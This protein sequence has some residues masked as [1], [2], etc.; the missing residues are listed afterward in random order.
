MFCRNTLQGNGTPLE[1]APTFE[2]ALALVPQFGQTAWPS[3]G[4]PDSG[5]TMAP[6]KRVHLKFRPPSIRIGAVSD[7][8]VAAHGAIKVTLLKNSSPVRM[9]SWSGVVTNWSGENI[10]VKFKE[11]LRKKHLADAKG[12]AADPV[13][14]F[15]WLV[16][17]NSPARKRH[18]GGDRW[19]G[20]PPAPRSHRRHF[21]HHR[22]RR[23][24]LRFRLRPG[25]GHQA[26]SARLRQN[27]GKAQK[28]VTT[29]CPLASYRPDIR[30]HSPMFQTAP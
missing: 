10:T 14:P 26:V 4:S 16:S 29:R 11:F 7:M 23:Q 13:T 6:P 15:V 18:V 1:R 17:D 5:G 9:R 25:R 30:R 19:K 2:Y 22:G 12:D 27:E 28:S 3:A 8:T 21:V 24:Q 20:Q